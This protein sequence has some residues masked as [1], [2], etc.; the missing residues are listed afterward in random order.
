MPSRWTGVSSSQY[1]FGSG[2][3]RVYELMDNSFR[4][5]TRRGLLAGGVAGVVGLA[6]CIRRVRNLSG[7]QTTEQPTL[8][9]KTLPSDTDPFAAQ[10]ASHLAGGL[11]AVGIDARPVPTGSEALYEQ[12]LLGRNFD[13]YIGQLPFRPQ[14]DPDVLYPLLHSRFDTEMGWQN[15]FGFADLDD[16]ELLERQRGV[17][18]DRAETVS[19]FQSR[20]ASAQPLTPIYLPDVIMGVR[21]DQFSGWEAAI[22]ELPYG[23]I[24]LE[25]VED[26]EQLQ[27]VSAD[28]R[29]TANWNPI[30]AVH[31]PSLSLLDLLY[32]PL[33]VDTGERQLSWLADESTWDDETA[34]MSVRLRKDLRWHD[35]EPLTAADV[36]FSYEFIA[37]TADGTATQPIPAPRFRGTSTLIED[38]VVEDDHQLRLECA[39]TTE[40]VAEQTLTVPILPEHIWEA[41]TDTVSVAGIEVDTETTEALITDNEEPVG[42]GPFK[43]SEVTG[44]EEVVFSRFE[45]HFLT[46]SDDDRLADF[47]GGPSFEEIVVDVGFSHGG[48]VELLAAGEAAA[49]ITPIAPDAIDQLADESEVTTYTHRSY[50]LYHLGFNTRNSPLSNPNFRRLVARLVDKAFLAEETFKGFGEPVASPLAATEWLADDLQWHGDKDPVVPFFGSNGEVDVDTAREAF[51][52]AGFRYDEDGELRLPEI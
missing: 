3:L 13:M 40:P 33:V 11:E 27:V 8:Q 1:C 52:E 21:D 6:G 14:S 46:S 43:F 38:V 31:R 51:V 48:A 22:E 26:T 32:E 4:S 12:L 39:E 18:A 23:L 19:E 2:T 30:S 29:L 36:A 37:D 47:H 49:T 24:R 20:L 10:V 28:N 5:T 50:G 44:G 17:D 15:P 16:D 41:Y 7:R 42:S 35:D 45:D 25:P 9:I 34:T